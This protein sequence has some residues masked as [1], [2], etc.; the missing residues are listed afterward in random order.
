MTSR[1]EFIKCA[2][3]VAALSAISGRAAAQIIPSFSTGRHGFR[4]GAS[5]F[6][7]PNVSGPQNL[8]YIGYFTLPSAFA[9]GGG[10]LAMGPATGTLYASGNSL[11]TGNGLGCVNIPADANLNGTVATFYSGVNGGAF[12]GQIQDYINTNTTQNPGSTRPLPTSAMLVGSTL[13]M[14]YVWQYP[15]TRN[16]TLNYV[17]I[18]SNLAQSSLVID[19]QLGTTVDA[20]NYAVWGNIAPEWQSTFQAD[21]I[22]TN[23]M[24]SINGAISFGEQAWFFNSSNL[25]STSAVSASEGAF[26]PYN[27]G[28]GPG[29]GGMATTMWSTPGLAF[30]SIQA[31]NQYYSQT[32]HVMAC[33]MPAGFRDLVYIIKHGAGIPAYGQP[34]ATYSL[35][36]TQESAGPPPVA[37]FYNSVGTGGK[38]D[39]NYPSTLS[40]VCYDVQ[41]LINVKNGTVASNSITPRLAAEIPPP[42]F[43]TQ[44]IVNAAYTSLDGGGCYDPATGRIY[45]NVAQDGSGNPLIAVYQ[46]QSADSTELECT[47]GYILPAATMGSAYSHQLTITGGTGPYTVTVSTQLNMAS[48]SGGTWLTVSS[49]GLITGTPTAQ[50]WD[51]LM[52]TITDSASHTIKRS[53]MLEAA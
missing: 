33:F 49:S 4:A 29:V 2:S 34:T 27:G 53:M 15:G 42:P 40:I 32:D 11:A 1:R 51:L 28:A 9:Y 19:F 35:N 14:S 24:P 25:G 41:D 50:E 31:P 20:A 52:I 26:F 37:Y 12:Q 39:V 13:F 43:M 7:N 47:D 10:C 6:S 17:K 3:G 44:G 45:L 36:G 30:S 48:N 16:Q 21:S 5:P 8:K 18:D 22:A 46:F 23:G 38:G